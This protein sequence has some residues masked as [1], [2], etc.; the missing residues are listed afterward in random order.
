LTTETNGT[1][2]KSL[3]F[4]VDRGNRDGRSDERHGRNSEAVLMGRYVAGFF[5][6]SL[7]LSILC[8][9]HGEITTDPINTPGNG[10]QWNFKVANNS[11]NE[12][13][14][15]LTPLRDVAGEKLIDRPVARGKI[16]SGGTGSFSTKTGT[17]GISEDK[18][19]TFLFEIDGLSSNA[20][21][22]AGWPKTSGDLDGYEQYGLGYLNIESGYF[23]DLILSSLAP[24]YYILCDPVYDVII[25]SDNSVQWSLDGSTILEPIPSN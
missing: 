10:I 11:A 12:I 14:I 2:A 4:Y 19:R 21:H 3:L 13:N 5:Q 7:L 20:I 9:C 16:N 17:P 22:M 15:T 6:L 1:K 18:L 24:H 25:A 8:C 23:N